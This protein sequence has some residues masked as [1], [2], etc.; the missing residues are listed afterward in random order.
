MPVLIRTV[1]G[2]IKQMLTGIKPWHYL[3]SRYTRNKRVRGR[4]REK[5]IKEKGQFVSDGSCIMRLS[6]HDLTDPINAST[7]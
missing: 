4:D 2:I 5:E 7:V 3:V 6:D 1:T